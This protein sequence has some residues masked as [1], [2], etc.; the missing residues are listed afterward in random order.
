MKKILCLFIGMLSC[1]NICLAQIHVTAD[2]R[3]ELTTIVARLTGM[4]GFVNNDVA[5]YAADIDAYFGK[6]RE[7]E[8]I[9]YLQQLRRDYHLA[10]NAMAG[11]A[12]RI[13]IDKNGISLHEKT[14]LSE[15]AGND[16]RWT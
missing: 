9:Q 11:S 13:E 2:E 4:S 15:V 6:Y 5:A 8:L 7:H 12:M 1:T 14:T 3:V 16:K 10:Y